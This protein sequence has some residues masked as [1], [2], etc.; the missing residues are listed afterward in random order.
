VNRK[1]K[2]LFDVESRVGSQRLDGIRETLF[3]FSGPR[4]STDEGQ[5]IPFISSTSLPKL[6]GTSLTQ[7]TA[8]GEMLL[9]FIRSP[10]VESSGVNERQDFLWHT[11]W[12]S[13]DLSRPTRCQLLAPALPSLVSI[14]QAVVFQ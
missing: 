7:D 9:A 12:K 3:G 1:F 11:E 8:N 6:R 10:H 5:K 2:R 14:R 4:V 13:P